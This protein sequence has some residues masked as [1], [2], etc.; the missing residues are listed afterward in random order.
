MNALLSTVNI[1]A[2]F[3][4][5]FLSYTKLD[6]VNFVY[7]TVHLNR[8]C[9]V[10]PK[11]FPSPCVNRLVFKLISNWA[12]TLG[13][14]MAIKWIEQDAIILANFQPPQCMLSSY[15]SFLVPGILLNVVVLERHS[16]L[17]LHLSDIVFSWYVS[18]TTGFYANIHNALIN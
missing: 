6:R 16:W 11:V 3:R 4:L 15:A 9:I 8:T 10:Q 18:M 13:I 1:I 7:E 14:N 12:R 2:K 5:L 17:A